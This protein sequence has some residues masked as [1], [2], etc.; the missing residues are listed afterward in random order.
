MKYKIL[1]KK[2]ILIC[3]V[4][5]LI[6]CASKDEGVHICDAPSWYNRWAGSPEN[7]NKK[8]FDY[9]YTKS[10]GRASNNSI[11][12]KNYLLMKTTCE[13]NVASI[14]NIYYS[15]LRDVYWEENESSLEIKI[16][17]DETFRKDLQKKYQAQVKKCE[18][19]YE[20]EPNK[21]D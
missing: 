21:P 12:S 13:Q 17:Q 19:L 5:N 9:F 10:K 8:P 3:F 18:P 15:L 11:K 2:L 16:T 6:Y 7:P 1:F 14:V 20:D 4:L